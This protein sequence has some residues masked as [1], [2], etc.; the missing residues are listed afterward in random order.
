MLKLKIY[1][2]LK[3]WL[4]IK[5]YKVIQM[6]KGDRKGLPTE[7]KMVSRVAKSGKLSIYTQ[8]YHLNP[9]KKSTDKK[10]K[11]I[12]QDSGNRAERIAQ[13]LKT[14]PATD[15][16][17]T[18]EGMLNSV[19]PQSPLGYKKITKIS[20][21]LK[22]LK[23]VNMLSDGLLKKSLGT[24]KSTNT[25]SDINKVN[26]HSKLF[27]NIPE[28]TEAYSVVLNDLVS[29]KSKMAN[30][31]F[32]S[33]INSMKNHSLIE[34]TLSS[35]MK[36]ESYDKDDLLHDWKIEYSN[37]LSQVMNYYDGDLSDNL[38]AI[39]AN[40]WNKENDLTYL[41]NGIILTDREKETT[42]NW[43]DL[44]NDEASKVV[45]T[46]LLQNTTF[47]KLDKNFASLVYASG[48]DVNFSLYNSIVYEFKNGTDKLN[49]SEWIKIKDVNIKNESNFTVHSSSFYLRNSTKEVF[50][51]VKLS[52]KNAMDY[53][54]VSLSNN[55]TNNF[56]DKYNDNIIKTI[57][58]SKLS[59]IETKNKLDKLYSNYNKVNRHNSYLITE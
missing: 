30:N 12:D 19:N 17:A 22:S 44:N 3:S 56:I 28:T 8:G 32:S 53:N 34:S 24:L 45:T 10:N 40:I 58:D 25:V 15:K 7:K 35:K 1:L 26:E 51:I 5:K 33:I 42:K 4:I 21:K 14:K 43:I 20:S 41:N 39:I 11:K 54:F 6:A 55:E 18:V 47:I 13:T 31:A 16:R 50:L 38:R 9:F 29:N 46:G 27:N 59:L 49:E 36:S 23:D 2:K 37:P 52:I 57:N 48:I